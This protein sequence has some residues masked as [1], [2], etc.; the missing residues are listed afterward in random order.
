MMEQRH[1]YSQP[2]YYCTSTNR[3]FLTYENC[4]TKYVCSKMIALLRWDKAMLLGVDLQWGEGIRCVQNSCLEH[5]MWNDNL[6]IPGAIYVK[7]EI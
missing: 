6:I 5:E 1:K 4:R 7:G 3:V 2:E